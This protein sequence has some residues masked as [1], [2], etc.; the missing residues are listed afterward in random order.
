MRRDS[1][2]KAV[3]SSEIPLLWE[4]T[5]S[6]LEGPIDPGSLPEDVLFTKR[7]SLCRKITADD[8]KAN[9]VNHGDSVRR[10]HS[11]EHVASTV[12]CWLKAR[13]NNVIAIVRRQTSAV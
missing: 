1:I 10:G 7:I 4:A 11:A 2:L 13:K 12:A 8:Y 3:S 6:F 9:M 5:R